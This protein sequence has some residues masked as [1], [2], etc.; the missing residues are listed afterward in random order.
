MITLFVNINGR[1][2]AIE[3][4]VSESTQTID[5]KEYHLVQHNNE[6]GFRYLATKESIQKAKNDSRAANDAMELI[7]MEEGF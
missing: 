3:A 6:G 4:R 1:L 2:V 7:A 5:G